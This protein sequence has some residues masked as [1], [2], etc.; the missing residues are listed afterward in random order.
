MENKLKY[1]NEFQSI[2]KN[3]HIAEAGKHVLTNTRLALLI[4]PTATGRDT[5]IAQLLKTDEYFYIVSDTTR[6]P[7]VN[8]G[9]P[10]KSGVE[11]WFRSEQVFLTD[12]ETGKLLE[13]EIIHNQQVSGISIRELA[14]A[15]KQHKIAITN[16]DLNIR[17]IV[18]VKPDTYAFM[19][20]PPSFEEWMKRIN[21][22]GMM[23]I[24]EKRRRLDTA[25]R[26]FQAG[27]EWPFFTFVI[28]DNIAGAVKQIN[29]VTH[30]RTDDSLQEKNRLI[31]QQLLTQTKEWLKAN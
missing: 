24:D 28:N 23:P 2:L 9:I 8:N 22:R 21:G 13:A 17:A 16:V 10:E 30:G 5:I 20:L 14:R 27:L 3:Y 25:S 11:Y 1:L 15:S 6:K 29:N 18:E 7:R 31:V 26:V 19:V 4:G 12:L